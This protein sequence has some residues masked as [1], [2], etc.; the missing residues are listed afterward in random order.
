VS[1]RTRLLVALGA[2]MAAALLGAGFAI[3]GLTRT[4][5]VDRI[6]RELLTIANAST[7]IQRL[8]DLADTDTE[9]GRRLAV[10]RLDRNGNVLRAFPS[11]FASDPDP[12]P[13]RR[14]TAR[15]S[16]GSSSSRAPGPVRR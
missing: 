4:A 6:D 13:A 16:T 9:A 15:S 11:G 14:P 7:R 12:L 8:S 10:M 2:V 3:L 5:L 1:L